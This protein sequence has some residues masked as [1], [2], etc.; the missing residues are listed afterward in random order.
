MNNLQAINFTA[1]IFA[2]L[3]QTNKNISQ[4]NGFIVIARCIKQIKGGVNTISDN[5]WRN[6]L[7]NF[8]Y[9]D[10]AISGTTSILTL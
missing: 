6:K 2:N 4:M 8:G 3:L 9:N 5:P 1:Q 10:K 7:T